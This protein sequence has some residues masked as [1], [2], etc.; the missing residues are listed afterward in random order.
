MFK[1]DKENEPEIEDIEPVTLKFKD[2]EKK[3]NK[4]QEVM[5]Q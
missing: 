1:V 2:S 4:K 5:E 3:S